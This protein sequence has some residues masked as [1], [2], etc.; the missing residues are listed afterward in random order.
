MENKMN[1]PLHDGEELLWA[2]QPEPFEL[3]DAA[4]KKAT[5]AKWIGSVVIPAVALGL[6]FGFSPVKQWG[7]GVA[8]V[9]IA[10]MVFVSP[11]LE[12]KK[13]EKVKFYMTNQRAMLE[14]AGNSMYSIDLNE[15]D[16]F[17]VV[18]DVADETCVVMGSV[19]FEE[20]YK[21]MR[22]RTCNPKENNT[23]GAQGKVDGL[24][25]YNIKDAQVVAEILEKNGVAKL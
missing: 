12:K 23:S 2:G 8:V 19:L 7:V 4:T 20:I 1:L 17:K 24:M 22:W 16:A 3:L 13:V 6:Y 14:L 5:I 10:I 25:F 21:Q 18:D 11:F 15:I 9:L